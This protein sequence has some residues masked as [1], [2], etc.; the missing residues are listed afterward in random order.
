MAGA[1]VRALDPPGRVAGELDPG[2]ADEVADLPRRPAAVGVD[3]EVGRDAEV[4]L[5]TRREADV[6]ADP[7][8]AER[9]DVLPVQVLADHVPAA[10]VR[11][12][13]VGVQRPL[14]LAVPRDRVV[15]E[16]DRPLL[17]DRALEL[18]QPAGH[19]RRVVRV[20]HLDS[21]GGLRRRLVEP[22]AAEGEILQSEPERLGVR[23][24]PLQEVQRG[25]QGRQLLVVELELVEEVVLGR[26][27]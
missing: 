24:L 9:A 3:V 6:A 4:A 27:V 22:R 1:A 15:R 14:A 26:S 13:P 12:Q 17:R 23:E 19:L 7:R 10:V 20:E 8:D 18:A 11:Q 2:L 16:L 25:L 5:A 21:D